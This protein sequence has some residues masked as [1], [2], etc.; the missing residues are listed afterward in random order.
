MMK[1]KGLIILILLTVTL[2][3][4][5]QS[6]QKRLTLTPRVGV[7]TSNVSGMDW[8]SGE[9]EDVK[10][11]ASIDT[12]RKWSIT[13]GCDIEYLLTRRLGLSGGLYYADEGY[14]YEGERV[15]L[16]QFVMPMM[17]NFY[18]LPRLAVKGGIS[19]DGMIN[20]RSKCAGMS[21]NILNYTKTVGLSIPVGLSMDIKQLTIDVRYM[22]G[23][24]DWCDN[25]QLNKAGTNWHTNSLWMTLG[26]RIGIH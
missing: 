8:Y 21:R 11:E 19:V 6:I 17:A 22:F 5:A 16:H 15:H 12:K 9:G 7:N 20:A 14:K 2:N 1:R 3:V 23:I 24:T 26:Y 10:V 13:V 25:R 18:I 4:G